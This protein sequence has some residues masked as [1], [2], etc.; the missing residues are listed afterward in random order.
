MVFILKISVIQQVLV[1]TILNMA[2]VVL[3]F[4]AVSSRNDALTTKTEI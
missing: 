1:L 3:C 2:A 4:M